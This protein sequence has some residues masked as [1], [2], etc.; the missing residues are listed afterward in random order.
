MLPSVWRF[1]S[2]CSKKQRPFSSPADRY[3]DDDPELDCDDP[4]YCYFLFDRKLDHDIAVDE[5]EQENRHKKQKTETG[6]SV[7]KHRH[8]LIR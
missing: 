7:Q 4:Y 1:W 2:D 8:I 5:E 6:S 3:P